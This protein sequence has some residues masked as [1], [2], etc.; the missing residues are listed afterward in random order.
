MK[1]Y[2][3]LKVLLIS[4][5]VVVLFSWILP[6]FQFQYDL[7]E[8]SRLQVGLFDLFSYPMVV[9]A[10]F[11]YVIVFALATGMFYGVLYKI[12]AYWELLDRIVKLFKGKEN[13]FLIITMILTAVIVSV[14]GLS[15]AMLFV[16][17]LIISLVLLMGYNKLVA[18]SVTVGSVMVGIAG[19]TLGSDTV[20][21]ITYALGTDVFNEITSKIVILVIG[22]IL[23]IFNVLLY[24]RKTKNNVDKVVSFVPKALNKS[25]EELT[26]TEKE[27]VSTSKKKTTEVKKPVVKK[28]SKEV[29]TKTT[30]KKKTSTTTKKQTNTKTTDKSTGKAATKTASTKKKTSASMAKNAD[31][32]KVDMT[33]KNKKVAVWPLVVIFD[34][35]IIIMVLSKIDWVGVFEIDFFST[36]FEAVKDF[37]IGGF[38][39][40]TKILGSIKEFGEWSLSAEIPALIIIAS[41]LLAFVYGL[42]LNDFFDGVI[43]G[44]KKAA[45][46]T[47]YM[48]LVYLILVIV[49]YHPFQLAFTQFFVGLTDQFNVIIMTII[50]MISS[51]FNVETTYVAQ[52]TLP[53][54]RSVY[55]DASLYPLISVISQSIYGLVML[56]APTSAILIGT[57]SYLDISYGQWIKHIWKLFLQLLAVF[58]I[59]FLIIFLI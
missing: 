32:V 45:G 5:L 9:C 56:I 11:S 24:A 36:A 23:L 57:L 47:I 37:T 43:A 19:T 58:V 33:K 2:N 39:I 25:K 8:V 40:F 15:F 54:L 52:S 46:P 53:Y 10:Y 4:I 18:A 31:V 28:D 55:T 34:L 27:K 26:V 22:L 49:T 12:P 14:T 42:K 50:S 3:I 48:S 7:Q 35:V 30:A 16:F 6:T 41:I 44:L 17:P 51:V 21:Y 13:I 29:D 1:K 38:P 59:I 20:N